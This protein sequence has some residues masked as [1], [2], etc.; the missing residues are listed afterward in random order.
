VRP[1]TTALVPTV[2]LAD[3][4]RVVRLWCDARRRDWVVVPVVYPGWRWASY[5]RLSWFAY[6]AGDD[7]ML[8]LVSAYA[9]GRTL[10]LT[11]VVDQ[12]EAVAAVR[13]FLGWPDQP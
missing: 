1:V 6:R 8:G 10:A 13:W 12:T 11:G 2:P 9:R 5:D 4:R 7:A 3:G